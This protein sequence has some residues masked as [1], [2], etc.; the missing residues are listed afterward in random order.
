MCINDKA[1]FVSFYAFNKDK[2]RCTITYI[3]NFCAKMT[4]KSYKRAFLGKLEEGL[5]AM[6][7]FKLWTAR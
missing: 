3:V 6:E 5:L 7:R 1:C 4:L 2:D